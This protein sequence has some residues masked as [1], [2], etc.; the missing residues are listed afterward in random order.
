M[1]FHIYEVKS[2][3]HKRRAFEFIKSAALGWF[4]DSCYWNEA[5]KYAEDR[6]FQPDTFEYYEAIYKTCMVWEIDREIIGFIGDQVETAKS[7]GI[8]EPP[9]EETLE[10]PYDGSQ[11]RRRY[12]KKVKEI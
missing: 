8:I 10:A 7:T 12:W 11:L 9:S 1:S 6:G 3:E 2:E 5:C 4:G